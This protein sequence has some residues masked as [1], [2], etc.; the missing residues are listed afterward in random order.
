MFGRKK[1]KRLNKKLLRGYL[2][3]KYGKRQGK[4]IFK[5]FRRV[6]KKEYN[7]K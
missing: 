2:T 6:L 5:R 1:G 4:K 3:S 7:I